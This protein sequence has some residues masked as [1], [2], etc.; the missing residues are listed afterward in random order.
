MAEQTHEFAQ[1]GLIARLDGSYKL[2][3]ELRWKCSWH[4]MPY[5]P[6]IQHGTNALFA[7]P[8]VTIKMWSGPAYAQLIRDMGVPDEPLDLLRSVI[9][10]TVMFPLHCC[11]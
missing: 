2:G 4:L 10:T 5:G 1:L 7:F 3:G 11:G 6:E 9:G 8:A